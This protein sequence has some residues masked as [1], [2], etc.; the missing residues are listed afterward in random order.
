[1]NQ[2][3]ACL[4]ALVIGSGA[5]RAEQETPLPPIEPVLES[6]L[7]DYI[8]PGYAAFRIA[9]SD[10]EASTAALCR[11]PSAATLESARSAFRVTVVYWGR[12]EWLRLGPVM[13]ENRLER[14]LFFPDRKGT[15][16]RQVQAAIAS[17][18]EKVTEVS[19]LSG[20]SVAMQGLGALEFILFGSGSNALAGPDASHRCAFAKA[21][22]TNLVNLSGEIIDGWRDGS[23]L[24]TAFLKP[25]PDNPLF[26][27]D[28]EAAN[29]L[30]GQ[31]LH[32][33]EAI[34]DIRIKAFFDKKNSDDDRPKSALF[35]RSEMTLPSIRADLEGLEAMFNK[36]GIEVVAEDLQPRIGATMRFEFEQAVHTARSLEV[37]VDAILSDPASREK[38]LYLD[39]TIRTVSRRLGRGFAQA[40]GLPGGFFFGDGD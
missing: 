27:T 40:R 25:G 8:R 2:I 33:I 23:G 12:M 16:R 39:Y 7:V 15:G 4:L 3:L 22:S 17:S 28:Q 19:S 13:D 9:A 29:L 20:Q 5:A 37:P 11:D 36:S 1:M 14:I 26:R 32:G 21:A 34:L 30:L 38:L 24:V 6:M 10:L 35:W 31:M 18:D